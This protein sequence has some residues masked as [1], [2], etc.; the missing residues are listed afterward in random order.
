MAENSDVDRYPLETREQSREFYKELEIRVR[1]I[2][3][4]CVLFGDNIR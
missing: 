3:L 1:K 2:R 4:Y